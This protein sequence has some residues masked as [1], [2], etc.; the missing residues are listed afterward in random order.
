MDECPLCTTAYRAGQM[1]ASRSLRTTRKDKGPQLWKPGRVPIDLFLERHHMTI[2]EDLPMG[3]RLSARR[4][5]E[6]RAEI[7]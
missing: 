4:S 3:R 2:I 1:Q 5:G 6:F 7:K